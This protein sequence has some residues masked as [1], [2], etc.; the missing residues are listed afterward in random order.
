MVDWLLLPGVKE[1]HA[2]ELEQVFALGRLIVRQDGE[3]CEL[4]QLGLKSLR[5]EH[6]VL[7][8]QEQELWEFHEWLRGRLEISPASGTDMSAR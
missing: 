3:V 5:H 8:P 6:G 2:A 7:V 1:S 4:N